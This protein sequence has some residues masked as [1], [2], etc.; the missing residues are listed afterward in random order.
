MFL[1]AVVA[2]QTSPKAPI[3]TGCKSVYLVHDECGKLQ[4]C[5]NRLPPARDF[6]GG[7]KDLGSHEFSHLEYRRPEDKACVV[8]RIV[9]VR[10]VGSS[11]NEGCKEG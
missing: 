3:P 6:K 7:P 9:V 4:D 8:N 10:K 11:P 2:Y 1:E 5:G